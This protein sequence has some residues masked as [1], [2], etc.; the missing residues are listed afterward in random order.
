MPGGFRRRRARDEQRV[1][2]DGNGLRRA[3]VGEAGLEDEELARRHARLDEHAQALERQRRAGFST[4]PGA[5]TDLRRAVQLADE[6]KGS[7]TDVVV[8]ASGDL[9]L[10]IRALA[11]ALTPRAARAA[12]GDTAAARLHVAD[13]LDPEA[14][15][16][17]LAEL[18]LAK[19]LFNVVDATGEALA[20]MGHFLIV[21]EQ[22]LR[23]LGAV[24]YQQRVVVTTRT[25]EGALRQIVNDEGFRS[26]ALPDD[27]DEAAALLAPGA[28]FPL[29]C[30]GIDVRALLAGGAAMLD[31]CAAHDD[32]LHPAHLVAVARDLA[33]PL[34]LRVAQPAADALDLLAAWIE[35]RV[36][37]DLADRSARGPPRCVVHRDRAAGARPRD[38]EGLPGSRRGGVPRRARARRDRGRT[39]AS[40]TS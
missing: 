24:E 16:A 37:G 26:L 14:F 17:L 40:A 13:R 22:L 30:V 27:A 8:L 18:D 1:R 21:R 36:A 7:V 33:A 5:K 10:G 32:S 4:P 31:R 25:A 23:E 11:A 9:G 34:G 20:T 29:A 35:R 38:P 12:E 28:L 2:V 39:S 19:T 6:V 3:V 15:G